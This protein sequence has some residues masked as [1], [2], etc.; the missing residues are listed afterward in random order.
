M[1]KLYHGPEGQG[2]Q[3]PGQQDRKAARVDVPSSPAEL[4][5]WL[6]ERAVPATSAPCNTATIDE[7]ELEASAGGAVLTES[8]VAKVNASRPSFLPRLSAEEIERHRMALGQCPKCG[9]FKPNWL[10]Q[11]I[12]GLATATLDELEAAANAIRDHAAELNSGHK[13]ASEGRAN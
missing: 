5:A 9:N 13:Q 10:R 1:T 12:D 3:I 8:D 6:N 4:A 2:W 7:L 11:V